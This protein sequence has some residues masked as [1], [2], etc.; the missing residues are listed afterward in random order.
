M[1]TMYAALEREQWLFVYFFLNSSLHSGFFFLGGGDGF[2]SPIR[3]KILSY[4]P[5]TK[6]AAWLMTSN[7]C[8]N[9]KKVKYIY[10]TQP[11]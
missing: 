3:H 8:V 10:G 9:V 5:L 6:S 4:A 7:F 1:A 11:L 2:A